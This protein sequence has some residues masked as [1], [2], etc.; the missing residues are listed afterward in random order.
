MQIRDFTLLGGYLVLA[1]VAI[2]AIVARSRRWAVRTRMLS[3]S[4]AI[5]FFFS[6]AIAACGGASIG[7]FSVMLLGSLIARLLPGASTA[8]CPPWA[9]GD[10]MNIVSFCMCFGILGLFLPL[11]RDLE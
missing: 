4:A 3:R 8:A 7:P 10:A 5:A 9:L 6:P 1:V 11:G 2:G